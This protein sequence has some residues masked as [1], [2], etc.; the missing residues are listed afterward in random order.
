MAEAFKLWLQPFSAALMV[1]KPQ[2][3]VVPSSFVSARHRT[4]LAMPRVHSN[5]SLSKNL[6]AGGGE[7]YDGQQRQHQ[8][9]LVE[10]YHHTN[11]LKTLLAEL[12]MKNSC[13]IRL[14]ERDG[15]W[16]RDQLWVA[17]RFLIEEGRSVDALKVGKRYLFSMSV[18]CHPILHIE[19][20]WMK[21][22]IE[23]S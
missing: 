15:D 8:S 20:S 10:A 4:T 12:S 19:F 18:V 6:A 9:L 2:I 21:I 1:C 3:H 16:L 23:L 5:L 11:S 17:V 22:I 13:P 7:D 14:L